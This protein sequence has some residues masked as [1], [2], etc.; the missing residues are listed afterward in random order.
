MVGKG[1]K[2]RPKG[3]DG[4]LR[5]D[6]EPDRDRRG[7]QRMLDQEKRIIS[8]PH[9]MKSGGGF[10]G[11]LKKSCVSLL[12]LNSH[13]PSF[14]FSLECSHNQ[15]VVPT[16]ALKQ[17][18]SGT[19]A[20]STLLDWGLVL[21]P[22][23]LNLPATLDPGLPFFLLLPGHSLRFASTCFSST[24]ESLRLVAPHCPHL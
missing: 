2:R 8:F 5:R 10:N 19:F 21:T 20:V 13:H 11:F 4:G 1:Q 3:R 18:L 12:F 22:F 14:Q 17:P 15:T 16:V 7:V 9:Q 24:S 23:S 6:D